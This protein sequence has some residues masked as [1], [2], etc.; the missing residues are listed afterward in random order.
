MGVQPEPFFKGVKR[1][2]L[3]ETIEMYLGYSGRSVGGSKTMYREENPNSIVY[4]NA[5][6]FDE[7]LAE[8]WWGDIDV[9]KDM[10]IL[11]TIAKISKQPFYVTPEHPYRADFDKVTYELLKN[12][13]LVIKFNEIKRGGKK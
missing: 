7:L 13:K 10:P 12:D 1:T 9:T 11:E 5:C 4:F 2:K 3:T 8:V 6:I